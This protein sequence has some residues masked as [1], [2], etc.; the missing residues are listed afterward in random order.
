MAL[1]FDQRGILWFTVQGGNFI[2]RLDQ[3]TGKIDLQ[4]V[5]TEDSLP[6]GL[7]ISSK[8]IP[9]FCEFGTNKVATVDPHTMAITE[10]ELPGAGTRPRRL[11]IA[12]DDTVYFTDYAEGHLGRLNLVN[13][14]TKLWASPGGPES[15][16]YGIAVTPDGMVW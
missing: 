10:F 9:V 14:A 7:V 11:S 5:P 8:G 6:Y 1:A 13:G 15:N 12:K 3:R 2:G 4:K 16:P